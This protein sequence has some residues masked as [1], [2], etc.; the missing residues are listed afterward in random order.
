M[1]HRSVHV[2]IPLIRVAR[3][4]SNG[5]I[6][7]AVENRCKM[8]VDNGFRVTVVGSFDD[9]G[10]PVPCE[11]V[12]HLHVPVRRR[13]PQ[14]VPALNDVLHGFAI[15]RAL[16]AAHQSDP[17]DLVDV[18]EPNLAPGIFPRALRMGAV[19]VNSIHQSVL[20]GKRRFSRTRHEVVK[21]LNLYAAR[22]A[23]LNLAVSNFARSGLL[24]H[25]IA[26]ER[27]RVVYNPIRFPRAIRDRSSGPN[28]PLRIVW[29]GQMIPRKRLETAVEA[30]KLLTDRGTGVEWVFVGDGPTRAAAEAA[31]SSAGLSFEF[32]GHVSSPDRIDEIRDTC[33]LFVVTSEH[34]ISPMV[35]AEAMAAGLPSVYS[36][37]PP[38]RELAGATGLPFRLDDACDLADRIADLIDD[39]ARRIELGREALRRANEMFDWKV[40]EA[41]LLEAYGWILRAARDTP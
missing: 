19:K 28:R 36:D 31:C 26:A 32:T 41:G 20:D 38:H 30:A 7:R 5:G 14:I 21:S 10:E 13:A 9:P 22:G 39:P 2:A 33:D 37:I 27:V 29:I 1:N 40:L 6:P 24:A 17:V 15:G 11:G 16:F 23:D 4:Y 3:G 25:G 12:R 34:E 8:L 35:V 18:Q